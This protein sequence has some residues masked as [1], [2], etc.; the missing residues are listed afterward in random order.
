M[1]KAEKGRGTQI[2]S[3]PWPDHQLAVKVGF[4]LQDLSEGSGIGTV[5][6]STGKCTTFS[7][8]RAAREDR[9]FPLL[10]NQEY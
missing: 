5:R 10:K 8:C 2:L 4:S 1:L 7:Y 9:G 3:F 6:S